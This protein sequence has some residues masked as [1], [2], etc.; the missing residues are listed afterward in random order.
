MKPIACLDTEPIMRPTTNDLVM[1]PELG[2]LTALD[3]TLATAAY[4]LLSQNP[5]LHLEAFARGYVPNA[6]AQ[7][8]NPIVSRCIELRAAIRAYRH[9]AIESDPDIDN[10]EF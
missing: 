1:A 5:G 6:Q 9:I 3:A 2:V 4:Q 8:A 10:L 7:T